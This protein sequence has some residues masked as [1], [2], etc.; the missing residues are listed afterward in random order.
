MLSKMNMFKL[1]KDILKYM[2]AYTCYVSII[3]GPANRLFWNNELTS[4]GD[5]NSGCFPRCPPEGI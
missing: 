4:N 3:S 5:T 2:Y 1:K